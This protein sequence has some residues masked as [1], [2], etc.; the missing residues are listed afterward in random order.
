MATRKDPRMK[1]I[2]LKKKRKD[3][4]CNAMRCSEPTAETFPDGVQL[5]AKHQG[6]AYVAASTPAADGA[7]QGAVQALVQPVES[8]ARGMLAQLEPIQVDSQ[9][10]L[11]LVG[12]VLQDIA[13]RI[14]ELE[15][16]RTSVTKPMMDAKKRVDSWFKPAAD[17]L[18]ACRDDLKG[19]VG[20]FVLGQETAKVAALQAGDHDKAMAVADPV[21]PDGLSKRVTYE[22]SV[23]D[24][25][26]VPA[27]FLCVD[28]TKVQAVVTALKGAAV[29]PG[30]TV[31]PSVGV[32]V[33]S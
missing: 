12:P 28:A 5:C 24:L 4:T 17:L 10:S 23:T 20:A 2:N 22:W 15:S 27:D 8:H 6:A 30:I 18:K 26:A 11:D 7:E 32:T 13:R 29:I 3:G 25:A 1:P 19:K 14:K 31:A 16:E 33:R 21:M 9:A